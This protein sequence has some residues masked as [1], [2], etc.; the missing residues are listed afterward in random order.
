MTK[1]AMLV[2]VCAVAFGVQVCRV[3]ADEVPTYDVRKTCKTDTQSYQGPGTAAPGANT[4]SACVADEQTAR[5]TLVAQW[6]QFAPDSRSR[7]MQ[8]VGDVAGL[9]SYVEL[10]TCLQMAK[11]V[12]SLPK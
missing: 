7:C 12:K 3:A 4:A 9:Q 11:D 5:A 6:T 8:M 1:L 10:L 2:S